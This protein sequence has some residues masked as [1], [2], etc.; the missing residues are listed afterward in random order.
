MTASSMTAPRFPRAAGVVVTAWVV[1]A[2][3]GGAT[4]FF[5]RLPFPG[6]QLIILALLAGTLV[7]ASSMPAL[8]AWIDAL[9]L[10]ALVGIN[11]V[12]FVGITFLVLAARGEIAPVFAARAG[13]GDI[14]TAVL[15][16]VLVAAGEP[17]TALGRGLTHAWNA[18]GLLDLVVAV[19][20]AT[21]VTIRGTTP[22]IAAVLSLPL[23]VV[24]TF[25]VPIL[26]ANH[27]VI[28]RRLLA[29]PA[30]TP[31]SLPALACACASLRRAARAV[32]QLY[33]T[34]LQ[35]TGLRATQFTLLQ[36]LE[37]KGT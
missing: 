16:L 36:A 8:R 26:L 10:R 27:V 23:V 18:F 30:M 28:F 31:E 9:P 4:G 37:R 22:G 1:L 3:L 19:G 5:V 15:A 32:T 14:A 6:P 12:R 20:T 34:E 17:R 33:D 13:W 2:L 11:A 21:V 24:P 35:G 7:A 29:A 25:F